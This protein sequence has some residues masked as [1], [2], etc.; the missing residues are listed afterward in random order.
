[1]SAPQRHSREII[2]PS[3]FCLQLF[4]FKL[5]VQEKEYLP[6]KSKTIHVSLLSECVDFVFLIIPP[7]IFLKSFHVQPGELKDKLFL[8]NEGEG[9]FSDEQ[10]TSLRR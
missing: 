8:V 5:Q 4:H 3:T 2:N 7:D 1:M 10:I 6:V 9:G